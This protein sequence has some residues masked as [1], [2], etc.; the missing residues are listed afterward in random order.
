L[1]AIV[2]QYS[3]L[4]YNDGVFEIF[5]ET[6]KTFYIATIQKDIKAVEKAAAEVLGRSATVRLAEEIV[7]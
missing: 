6:G 3:S 1:A 5:F 2:A 4:K 7:S